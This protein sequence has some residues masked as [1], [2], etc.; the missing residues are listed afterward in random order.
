M[1]MIRALAIVGLMGL[2]ACTGQAGGAATSS[3]APGTAVPGTGV[4]G[5]AIPGT[6]IPGTA[7]V[8]DR[9]DLDTPNSFPGTTR[10]GTTVGVETDIVGVTHLPP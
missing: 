1:M 8:G 4:P 9:E 10:Q 6:A 2:G 3:A 7:G 5:A